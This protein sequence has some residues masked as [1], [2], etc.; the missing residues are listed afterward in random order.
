M[1]FADKVLWLIPSS[2]ANISDDVICDIYADAIR[3][4]NDSG[5]E[6]VNHIPFRCGPAV[7]CII[8]SAHDHT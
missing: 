5:V 1:E 2:L 6:I 4:D 7:D 3:T 8:M